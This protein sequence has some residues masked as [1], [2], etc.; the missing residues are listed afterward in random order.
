MTNVSNK[1]KYRAELLNVFSSACMLCLDAPCSKACKA[2]FD[3]AGMVRA[4]RFDNI[5]RAV[6]LAGDCGGCD[7]PCERACV[8]F[9]GAVRIKEISG[10]VRDCGA[11]EKADA[12][13]S[14]EFCG[15]KCENPF[16]LSSSV[17]AS[18]Y[19]MC[20]KALAAGWAGIVYKT[21]GNFIPE[22]VSPRFDTI[23]KESTPFIGFGNLE[24]ISDKSP[25]ENFEILSEL[26]KKFPSKI[27]VASIMGR[28]EDEWTLLAKRSEECGA[29]MIECNFSCPHMSA[30]GL[31]ADVGTNPELVAAYT[32]AVRRGSSLP[33]L[34]KMTPNLQHMEIPA[35]AAVKAGADG[36]AAINTIRSIRGWDSSH[37]E[38]ILSVGKR[39]AVSGYSGKAVKPIALRF[40]HDMAVCEELR[41]VPIS[42]MGGIETWRDAVDFIAMG[43]LNLQVTTAVMEYGYRIIDDLRDG[44]SRYLAA[45]GRE[46]V[47]EL[48]GAALPEYVA[49]DELDRTT[50]EYPVFDRTKCVGC[51]RCVISCDDGGHQAIFFDENSRKPRLNITRCVG[52]QLCRLVCPA[53]AIGKSK[54]VPKRVS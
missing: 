30:H 28:D 22:E 54:R 49:T 51:G 23:G 16:F 4:V 40:I 45:S 35:I 31:G 3:P 7:A 46:S 21:I 53:G 48:C 50:V 2:G 15:V 36:L 19:E 18:G 27:I 1:S 11:P 43:C 14:V 25:D 38:P 5:G 47:K 26:K 29:D 10:L 9:S 32:R 34:A 8:S 13:L 41:G 42:G 52:C 6:T 33:V 44:L 20:E 17:V 24:Q 39:S 37:G 12:D